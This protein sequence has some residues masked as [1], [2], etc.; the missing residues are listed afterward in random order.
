L[1]GAFCQNLPAFHAVDGSGYDFLAEQIIALNKINPHIAARL[2]EPFTRF[3][4]YDQKRQELIKNSLNIIINTP[5]LSTHIYEVVSKS[6]A[7]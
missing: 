5:D 4:K 7:G 3:K 6:L 2:C 1:I